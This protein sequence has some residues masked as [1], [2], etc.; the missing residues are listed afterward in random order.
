MHYYVNTVR[1][2]DTLT[3][4]V[5]SDGVS[6]VC[7]MIAH[8][9][10]MKTLS[11]S[12]A[13]LAISIPMLDDLISLLGAMASSSLAL[14]FPALLDLLTHW[15][16][17]NYTFFY[18]FPRPVWIVKNILIITIGLAGCG[19]GTFAASWNIVEYFAHNS[20]VSDTIICQH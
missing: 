2:Q 14:T 1:S 16:C 15:S 17:K 6:C 20:S 9:L 19:C 3:I 4:V 7:V 5:I 10:Y 13:V 12:S 11:L 18:V 8:L